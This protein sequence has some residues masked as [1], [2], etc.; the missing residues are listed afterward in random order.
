V[1]SSLYD[2]AEQACVRTGQR[3]DAILCAHARRWHGLAGRT[4]GM[5][6]VIAL[7]EAQLILD[8]ASMEDEPT[9]ACIDT[10]SIYFLLLL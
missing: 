9:L 6:K 1:S 8:R 7:R 3:A 2:K 4:T 10:L 5:P